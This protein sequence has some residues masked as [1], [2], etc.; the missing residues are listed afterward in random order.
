MTLQIY[1]PVVSSKITQGWGEN[2]ACVWPNGKITGAARVCPTGSQSFYK[3]VGLNGHNGIDI[4]TW[5]GEEIY[6]AATFDGWWSSEVD[7]MGGIG[8]DVI[9]YEPL[10]F[11][12]PIPTHL[13]NT[14]V[15]KTVDGVAGFEHY[16]KMRYWHLKAPLGSAKK[17]ITVGT[18]IGLAGNTGASSGPH[19]HF[20]PKWCL[21]DGRGVGQTNGYAGAFDPIPYYNHDFTAKEHASFLNLEQVPL[22]ETEVKDMKAQLNLAQKLL[23]MLR[24]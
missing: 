2:R 16:V 4:G 8:V 18:V 17:R 11:P 19:L 3:S 10:F 6:H 21:Q 14:A 13:I 24:K 9:S 7:S 5:T 15:P 20:A 23:N 22:S 12:F 1:R